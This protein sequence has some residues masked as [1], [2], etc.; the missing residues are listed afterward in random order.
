MKSS[1]EMEAAEPNMMRRSSRYLCLE[2]G[3]HG[4]DV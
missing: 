2:V 4:G 1:M 3:N